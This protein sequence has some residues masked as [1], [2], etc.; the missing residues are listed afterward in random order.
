MHVHT[1]AHAHT[2][3]HT[4]VHTH[5]YTQVCTR[6]HTFILHSKEGTYVFFNIM[7][8][9][10]TVCISDLQALGDQLMHIYVL[11]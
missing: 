3:I 2:E 6:T 7:Q 1:C 11:Q 8:A 9:I 10:I 5:R 4:Y